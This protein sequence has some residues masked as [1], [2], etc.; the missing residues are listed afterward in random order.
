MS[1][2][3]HKRT[4]QE[5][6]RDTAHQLLHCLIQADTPTDMHQ[7]LDAAYHCFIEADPLGWEDQRFPNAFVAF[8]NACV[9]AHEDVYLTNGV[10]CTLKVH[11]PE[12]YGRR[13]YDALTDMEAYM[14]DVTWVPTFI[15]AM[16]EN[17]S[18]ASELLKLLKLIHDE[19]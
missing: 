7:I 19:P 13:L 6:A 15:D 9:K 2:I 1:L 5:I 4:D 14:Y 12:Y 3:T 16:Y 18:P 8:E 10:K 17:A 11:E